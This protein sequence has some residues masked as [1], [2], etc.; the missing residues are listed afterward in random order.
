MGQ[1]N[2]TKCA[3]EFLDHPQQYVQYRYN[4]SVWLIERN[5][6]ALITS[7]GCE[8]LCGSGSDFYQWPQ[9]ASNILTW[10]LPV[11][12]VLLQAPWES[13]AFWR[14]EIAGTKTRAD[15]CYCKVDRQPYDEPRLYALEYQ[16]HRKMC[17][18]CKTIDN[19]IESRSP[20]L[21]VIVG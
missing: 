8:E 17:D 11:I 21:I 19:L 10:I 9:I 16:S 18:A 4:G 12:G 2:F 5:A 7:G 20:L 6:S 13:N 1:T 15:L 14:T 3:H